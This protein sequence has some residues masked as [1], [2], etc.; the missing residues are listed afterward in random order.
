MCQT[1]EKMK[2]MSQKIRCQIFVFVVTFFLA[3]PVLAR[4]TL[5]ELYTSQGCSTCP[6]GEEV[7]AELNERDD[8]FALSFHVD[9]WDRL[10]WKDPLAKPKFTQRQDGYRKVLDNSNLYTPQAVLDGV[11]DT[12]AAWAWRVKMLA[13]GIREGQVDIPMT[14]HEGLLRVG[15]YDLKAP[16]DIWFVTYNPKE[17]TD[18]K[19]GENKGRVMNSVNVVRSLEKLF[20]WN[21]EAT[22][23]YLPKVKNAGERVAVIIQ[24]PHLGK[25][26]G[27]YHQ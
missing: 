21:G 17:K 12:N 20:V 7:V 14:L 9:Y 2:A 5:L 19:A 1:I 11:D 25:V 23:I 4:P 27:L 6:M 22:N 13:H 15:G 10:G 3:S 16:A 18:I 26:L 24:E 8:F